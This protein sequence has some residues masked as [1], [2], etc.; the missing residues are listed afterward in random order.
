MDPMDRA[1]DPGS[2]GAQRRATA[3]V[4]DADAA[5]A[6]VID[7]T[8]RGIDPARVRTRPSGA[9]G[10]V[11]SNPRATG[12]QDIETTEQAGKGMAAGWAIGA[13]VGV[14]V[15]VIGTSLLIAPPWESGLALGITIAVA[16]GGAWLWGGLGL[17]QGGIA[18]TRETD[19][20][21]GGHLLGNDVVVEVDVASPEE[22]R[23]A[24]DV[25]RAHRADRID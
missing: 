1:Q 12:E 13:V 3:M 2:A 9:R 6:I 14:I 11:E 21:D 10:D 7:L 5:D 4:G 15:S 16:I 19:P 25:F 8:D 18:R 24:E 20:S 17:L 22:A 23:M